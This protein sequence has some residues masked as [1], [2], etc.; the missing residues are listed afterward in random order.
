MRTK[1]TSKI[2]SETSEE[3]KQ[4]VRDTANKLV[5]K[6]ETL[7][8]VAERLYPENI[9]KLGNTTSY[10]ASSIKRKDFIAG[11]K[12]QQKNSYGEEEVLDITQQLRL[13]LKL[14]VLKWQDDFEFDLDEWF[15]Q[16]KKK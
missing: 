14:G 13:K 2:L 9:I 7:E 12:W 6:K 16:F 10:D 11:A 15:E 5:M 8:E 1:T 3:T 4:Q